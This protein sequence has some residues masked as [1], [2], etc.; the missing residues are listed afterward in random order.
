MLDKA[1]A[2]IPFLKQLTHGG[3]I[4]LTTPRLRGMLFLYF[5]VAAA[6]AIIL[7]NTVVYVKGAL[8]LGDT[9]V[10][11]F[12]AVSGIGSMSVVLFCLDFC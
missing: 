11:L 1:K 2:Q 4:Y 7:V 9:V 5:G 12:F 8:G 10:V 3:A 6:T